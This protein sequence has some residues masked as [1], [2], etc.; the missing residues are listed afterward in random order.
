MF[1]QARGLLAA[2]LLLVGQSAVSKEMSL[3]EV[4][5]LPEAQVVARLPESHP[6]VLY[7]FAGRLFGAGRKDEGVMWFYAGQLRY[8]YHLVANPGLPPDGDPAVMASL[9]ATLGQTIDEW[10]GGLPEGWTRAID[11]ALVWDEQFPNALT[12]KERHAAARRQVRSGIEKCAIK[13]GPKRLRSERSERAE[14][15]R[16]G[17]SSQGNGWRA[18][19]ASGLRLTRTFAV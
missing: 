6:T 13:S 14:A 2:A 4:G 9:N 17:K 8:R 15:L 12:P 11:Q 18:K 1:L 19:P 16:T 5:Q 7:A 3:K 10:A